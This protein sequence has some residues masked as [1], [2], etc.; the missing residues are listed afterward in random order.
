ML[1]A[2]GLATNVA[3]A[4]VYADAAPYV[5]FLDLVQMALLGVAFAAAAVVVAVLG[6]GGAGPIALAAGSVVSAAL[7]SRSA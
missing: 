3:A 1:A 6:R 4:A 5:G 2:V 7:R